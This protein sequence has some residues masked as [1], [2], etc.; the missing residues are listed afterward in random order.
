MTGRPDSPSS[1]SSS[2]KTPDFSL[3]DWYARDLGKALEAAEAEALQG[4]TGR[5]FGQVLLQIGVRQNE[6]IHRTGFVH[7]LSV[8]TDAFDS[9]H[10]AF[11]G[12]ARQMPVA[13]DGVCAVVLNHALDFEQD[14]HAVLREVTRMLKDDGFL[15]VVGFNPRSLWGLRRLLP[16]GR[17]RGPWRARFVSASR[18]KDWLG[19]L[20]YQVL[21]ERQVF[22]RP[23]LQGR[24]I[25]ERI[26]RHLQWM[27]RLGRR[28][29]LGLGGV[30]VLAARRRTVPMSLVKPRWKPRR[31]LAAGR[32]GSPAT[33]VRRDGTPRSRPGAAHG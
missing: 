2:P 24:R 29:R 18:L 28:F 13:T 6:V 10:G 7:R 30:Y 16:V 3:S 23:P 11:R 17:D 19:L 31:A 21:D 8:D 22:F 5:L 20:D 15:V 25:W 1:P 32:L 4:V 27:E 14:P 26:M 9:G 12:R 33:R